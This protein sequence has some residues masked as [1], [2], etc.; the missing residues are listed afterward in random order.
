MP[1]ELAVGVILINK[2]K[3]LLMRRFPS[4]WSFLK[5]NF[6]GE[7]DKVEV[8]RQLC[9]EV[10]GS[11]S[12]FHVKGFAEK[13]EYFYTKK[14]SKIHK[15]ID[16]F[17]FETSETK[18]ADLSGEYMAATWLEYE[19]AITRTTFPVEKDILKLAQEHLKYNK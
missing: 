11:K 2:D 13:A 10:L 16:F 4:H 17:I 1:Q 9:T 7:I 19:R 8:A 15:E 18:Y 14:G 3:F 12:L 5:K 6:E